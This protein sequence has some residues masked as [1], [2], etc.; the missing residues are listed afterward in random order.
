M[1]ITVDSLNYEILINAVCKTRN[2]DGL[3]CEIGTRAGGSLKLIID[4]ILIKKLPPRP[5][6]C[7]DPYGCID[8]PE[9]DEGKVIR[10]DYTNG[11]R[12]TCLTDIYNYLNMV[13][14]MPLEN[15]ITI[16]PWQTPQLISKINTIFFILEDFEFFNR[17]GD[18]VPV[19]NNSEK[20][21]YNDY[22][23]VFLDGPHTCDALK[24]EIDFFNL[25][26]KSGA[27][28]VCD[29]LG[30]YNH[31]LVEKYLF[32][33]GFDLVEKAERKASYIKK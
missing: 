16:V 22:S 27:V 20:K 25:R 4:T 3:I 12:D 18:G 26:M 13:S 17:F 5:I 31:D 23:L 6:I 30:L 7:I 9:G 11:M 29:D 33:N 24:R 32:E 14:I 8:Y 15:K 2:L 21:I 10:Q 1:T 19:Y 28:I